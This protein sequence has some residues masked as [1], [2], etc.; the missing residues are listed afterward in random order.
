MNLSDVKKYDSCKN[1]KKDFLRSLCLLRNQFEQEIELK[2]R[3][4][5][6]KIEFELKNSELPETMKNMKKMD[7]SDL[8]QKINEM[9]QKKM[10][11]KLDRIKEIRSDIKEGVSK[12]VK[13]NLS[14]QQNES[15]ITK[16]LN[17]EDQMLVD[18]EIIEQEFFTFYKELYDEKFTDEAEK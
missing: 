3:K 4:K 11:R 9:E 1:D 17:G 18:N 2:R 5:R 15:T 12:E 10:I 7:I 6:E 16:P 8:R 14:M 13:K